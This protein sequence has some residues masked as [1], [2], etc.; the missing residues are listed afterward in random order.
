V[1]F[2]ALISGFLAIISHFIGLFFII[3]FGFKYQKQKYVF[4]SIF[5]GVIILSYL[6]HLIGG[7]VFVADAFVGVGITSAIFFYLLFQK[8]DYL[9]AILVTFFVNVAYSILRIIVF[10]KSLLNFLNDAISQYSQ[11]LQTSFPQDSDKLNFALEALNNAKFIFTHFTASIWMISTVSALYL[12]SLFISKKLVKW[13]HR[14]IRFPFYLVYLLIV[15]LLMTLANQTKY[16]GINGLIMLFPLFLIQGIS[17][18]HFFWGNFFRNSRFLVYL[19]IISML[20]NY[21]LLL[22]V[23][24]VGLADVWFNFRKINKMEDVNESHLN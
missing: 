3:A 19:L 17:I 11:I 2:A 9:H 24:F 23:A 6:F 22:L 10:Q 5:I 4:Y 12:G 1:V 16:W 15:A 18:L 13:N 7:S 8:F 21:F 20:L 14:E